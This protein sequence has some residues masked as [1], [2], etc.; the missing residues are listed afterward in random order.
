MLKGPKIENLQASPSTYALVLSNRAQCKWKDNPD[1]AFRYVDL[2]AL[3]FRSTWPEP[4]LQLTSQL[5]V[6]PDELVT[7]NKY[8][9]PIFCTSDWPRY[10]TTTT[11]YQPRYKNT[12]EEYS[13][14]WIHT[15]GTCNL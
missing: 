11:N 13:D 15:T 10:K 9:P 7:L 12:D 6:C 1:A 14:T 8:E 2:L 3:G 5:Q 4:S